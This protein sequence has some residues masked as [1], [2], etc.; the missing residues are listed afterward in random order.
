M[1]KKIKYRLVMIGKLIPFTS[2]IKRFFVLSFSVSVVMM[3]LSFV[4]P[5]FYKIFINNVIINRQFSNIVFVLLGYLA[6]FLTTALLGYL[7]NYSTNRMINRTTFHVRLKI[8]N[9][10]L[11]LPFSDYE[12]NSIGDMKMR[13]DDDTAQ[14]TSFAGAQTI[15]Y[16]IAYMTVIVS[17]I[18][19]FRIS[20]QLAIFAILVIPLTFWLDNMVSKREKIMQDSNR[21]NDQK[22]SSWLHISVG[23]WREI[24][25]L[26]LGRAMERQNIK[27][28][29]NFSLFYSRW[30]YCWV[31]R[32]I[33]IPLTKD[34][35][36]MQFGIYFIGGLLIIS[37]DLNI[38]SLLV[39][40]IY[41]GMLSTGINTV[42]NADAD[43]QASMPFLDR[44]LS[45]L[46]K[47]ENSK[48]V[49]KIAPDNSNKIA[50][51]DVSFAYTNAETNI[52]KNLSFTIDKGERVAITGKSGSGKTTVLKLLTGMIIP[53]SG[54][55]TFSK[56]NLKDIDMSQMLGRIGFVMQENMLF[57]TTI[58]E[59][60]LYGKNKATDDELITACKKSYIYDLISGL[61]DGFDTVIGEKGLKLSGGQRQRVVLARLFLRDVDIFIFDEATS[62]LDQYSESIIHDAI[63]NISKDKTIIVVAHRK[64][65][66]DLC[67][68]KISIGSETILEHS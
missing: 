35:I 19:L 29:H 22:W 14:I 57:N 65:S 44:L 63:N 2:G 10:F 31:L 50:F 32:Y 5:I 59:N 54:S 18:L 7:K 42:S 56:V 33:I 66:V 61:P 24:K 39:F 48:K 21:E 36:L 45:E 34:T 40:M 43:L 38:G 37:G 51:D 28:N 64:S 52:I 13:M 26:N 25:A 58:R 53:D 20:W 11:K 17:T 16:S 15:D 60:L 4:T 9:G 55:V 3:A 8:L 12:S 41:Y 68:R 47:K 46:A 49:K 23:G 6:V 27:Y 30:I 67:D 62:A 1:L